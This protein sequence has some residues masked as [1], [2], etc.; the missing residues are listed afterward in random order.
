MHEEQA[1]SN[2]RRC[3]GY[4]IHNYHTS[5]DVQCMSVYDVETCLLEISTEYKDVVYPMYRMGATWEFYYDVFPYVEI[6]IFLI[7]L[8]IL[9]VDM[10]SRT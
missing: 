3:G 9:P 7:L 6:L 2:I 1:H 10:Y 8:Y 5:M 4:V